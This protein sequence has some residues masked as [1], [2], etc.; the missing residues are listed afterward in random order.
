M[1][2][3]VPIACPN[4]GGYKV[5]DDKDGCTEIGCLLATGGLWFFVMLLQA[6]LNKDKPT[7][8]GDKLRCD[9]CGYRWVYQG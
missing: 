5:M 8:V 1:P 7:K 3:L 6:Y 2:D 4:C 9:I